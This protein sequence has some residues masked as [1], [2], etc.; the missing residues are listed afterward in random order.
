MPERL[1][2][3]RDS[4]GGGAIDGLM[5]ELSQLRCFVAAAEELHFGRAA[6]RLNMTQPP[7]SRQIQLLERILGGSL[8]GRTSRV[9]RLT[10]AGRVFLLEARR[11]IRLAES[12]TLATR[13]VAQG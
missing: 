9:V 5:F 2:A 4:G 7:L 6:Q 13:R 3:P 10:P 8:L 1:R 11:I 12:A